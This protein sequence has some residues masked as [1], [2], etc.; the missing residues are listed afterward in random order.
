MDT[1]GRYGNI[2]APP[3]TNG[4]S[5]PVYTDF[6][7]GENAPPAGPYGDNFGPQ[8]QNSFWPASEGQITYETIQMQ[9]P[10]NV[11]DFTYNTHP[12]SQV[13]QAEPLLNSPAPVQQYVDMAQLEPSLASSMLIQKLPQ[14]PSLQQPAPQTGIR[15]GTDALSVN[16]QQLARP[17]LGAAERRAKRQRK[18]AERRAEA[19]TEDEAEAEAE[20][21]N[22]QPAASSQSSEMMSA[23]SSVLVQGQEGD[24]ARERYLA[25]L[26]RMIP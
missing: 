7:E 25:L 3:G 22:E 9:P 26:P 13:Y 18:A 6:W 15:M 2:P 21:P 23:D 4:G 14:P 12:T 24:K 5:V 16:V 1:A 8:V 11:W 20:P 19:E 10:S 17:A